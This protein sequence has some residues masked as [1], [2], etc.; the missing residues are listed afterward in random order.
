MSLVGVYH[1][2]DPSTPYI[3]ITL[4]FMSMSNAFVNLIDFLFAVFGCRLLRIFTFAVP[5]RTT[6]F[7]QISVQRSLNSHFFVVIF[8][9]ESQQFHGVIDGQLPSIPFSCNILLITIISLFCYTVIPYAL[10]T[11]LYCRPN[12]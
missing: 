2:C 4:L 5:R 11:Y 6:I 7:F 3:S 9:C 8:F 1:T 12:K 10:S